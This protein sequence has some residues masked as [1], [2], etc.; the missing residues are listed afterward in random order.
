MDAARHQ[1]RAVET[2]L[3]PEDWGAMRS[4]GH[5]AID[6][7]IEY[8]S[9]LRERAVWQPIPTEVRR[10]F[11]TPLPERGVGAEAAY[12]AFVDDVL[13]YP[14]GNIH[15]RFWAWVVGTGSALGTLAALGA[16]A[17]NSNTPGGQSANV[18]V[19]EQLLEWL[20]QAL[21]YPRDASGVLVTG[22]SVANLVGVAVGVHDRAGFD[23]ENDGLY[24][25]SRLT[26]YA[27]SETHFS[28]EKAVRLLGLGRTSLR[29]VGVDDE[30]RIDIDALRDA[31]ER[32]REAGLRP[33]AVVGNAGTVGTGAFDDL[34]ALA[35][36]AAREE[37]WLH[38]DGAFGAIAKLSPRF[39]SLTSGL[40]R[41]DSVAF[42]LHKWLHAPYEAGCVLV[43][44]RD[45]H[46][47][48]FR[49]TA[50]YVVDLDGGI[51]VRP[52]RF[53]DLGLEQSRSSR[54]LGMWM[55]LKEHGIA[56]FARLVEQNVDQARYLGELIGKREELEL[57]AP[58][59][60]NIVCFRYR[61]P[62]L[63]D[64]QLNELNQR[65]LVALQERGVAAP[66]YTILDGR[67]ALRAAITN[68]RSRREDFE[69]LI[70]AVAGIGGTMT[71]S[72]KTESA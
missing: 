51:G 4:L 70:D 47:R 36:L 71:D 50:P 5:R 33:V 63:A 68:H 57:M 69:A 67:F 20:K 19:E 49:A 7:V 35:D 21:D 60:L 39:H 56:Q 26:V 1:P 32:D 24:G 41:A 16:A 14:Y 37:L 25:G 46:L 59:P 13:P 9:T 53:V 10:R 15:P 31:I 8:L 54:A 66:S 45:A 38:V 34:D 3:D 12:Q 2:S 40:E 55:S 52:N 72:D 6:D 58:V 48:A 65:I 17:M 44:D 61:P 27:S 43:R 11:E 29:K 28:V 23:I 22:G 64:E 42:D 62:G 30:Y 18:L